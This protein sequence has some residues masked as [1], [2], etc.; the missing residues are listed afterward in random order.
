MEQFKFLKDTFTDEKVI[1]PIR[2]AIAAAYSN[3]TQCSLDVKDNI[4]FQ[5]AVLDEV[6]GEVKQIYVITPEQLTPQGIIVNNDNSIS[7]T[8]FSSTSRSGE[9]LPEEVKSVFND[10]NIYSNV[11]IAPIGKI[12]WNFDPSENATPT[13]MLMSVNGEYAFKKAIYTVNGDIT[14]D[15]YEVL[16][17]AGT[18]DIEY[19][20]L[21]GNLKG[22]SL[23]FI[24]EDNV[25]YDK[26]IKYYKATPINLV[27]TTSTDISKIIASNTVADEVG[28]ISFTVTPRVSE[29]ST[30]QADEYYVKLNDG[31]VPTIDDITEV[32]EKSVD[33]FTNTTVGKLNILY[34]FKRT[35]NIYTLERI[36][37]FQKDANKCY[38]KD[39]RYVYVS[40]DAYYVSN[41]TDVRQLVKA[42]TETPGTI[43]L[44]P[45]GN[46]KFFDEI[47]TPY[48][49]DYKEGDD[50]YCKQLGDNTRAIDKDTVDFDNNGNILPK[51][52]T[53][54][55][56]ENDLIC[57]EIY[58]DMSPNKTCTIS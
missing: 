56:K 22:N 55:T 8:G 34:I 48:I 11:K 29:E 25:W 27:N 24:A 16:D 5:T 46:V 52:Y 45:A 15:K 17:G 33:L 23:N 2:G 44:Y 53:I 37:P 57:F 36:V 26:G 3:G 10:I 54:T 43:T 7:F 21:S 42:S 18:L 50:L 32:G 49:T 28:S 12:N 9:E 4:Y 6:S 14:Y 47:G 51:N 19:Y 31:A 13:D 38:I 40:E 30:I 35:D 41:D 1:P 58:K 20:K 39:G